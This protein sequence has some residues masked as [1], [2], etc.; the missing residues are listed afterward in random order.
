MFRIDGKYDDYEI[1]ERYAR[2]GSS[3]QVQCI[4]K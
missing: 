4:S 2:S 3:G 1:A